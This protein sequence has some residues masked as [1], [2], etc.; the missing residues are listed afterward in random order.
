MTH[1]PGS[2]GPC[3][4]A[5]A[6]IGWPP[7]AFSA[8]ATPPPIQNALFAALTTASVRSAARSPSRISSPSGGRSNE[9]NDL[10][11]PRQDVIGQRKQRVALGAWREQ[12]VQ[13]LLRA[14]GEIDRAAVRVV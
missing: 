13:R 5:S 10:P 7:R 1:C 3:A 8:P 4:I 9:I 2:T 6:S 14:L 12:R 11:V